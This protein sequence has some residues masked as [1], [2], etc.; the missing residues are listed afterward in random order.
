MTFPENQN[1]SCPPHSTSPPEVLHTCCSL[2]ADGCRILNEESLRGSDRGFK[3]GRLGNQHGS[4]VLQL[5]LKWTHFQR[6]GR[7]RCYLVNTHLSSYK[8]KQ[9]PVEKISVGPLNSL[10]KRSLLSTTSHKCLLR[11]IKHC[12][13]FVLLCLKFAHCHRLV[14]HGVKHSVACRTNN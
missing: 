5:C 7:G 10:W 9:N 11:N 4:T 6:R 3:W 1:T 12:V 8:H 14:I 13:L 2:N